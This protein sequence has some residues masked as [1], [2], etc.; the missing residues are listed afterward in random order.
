MT[1]ILFYFLSLLWLAVYCL[2]LVGLHRR[3]LK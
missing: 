2:W 3:A 1:I